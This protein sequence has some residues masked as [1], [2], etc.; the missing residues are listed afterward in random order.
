MS[1]PRGILIAGNWKMNHGMQATRDFFST[2]A[3]QAPSAQALASLRGGELRAWT[4]PPMTSLQTALSEAQ[5]LSFQFKIGAQNVHWE[6]SGAFTGEISG[7]MLTELGISR[8]L[9]GHSE[10]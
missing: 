7:P 10:R 3:H 2:F 8:A 4:F 5:K 9:T 1:K 6:N